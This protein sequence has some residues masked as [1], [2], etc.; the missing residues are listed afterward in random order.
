M[1]KELISIIV[2]VYNVEEYLKRC[3]DSLVNQ[4]YSN[5]EIILVNDGSTDKSLSI[6]KDYEKKSNGKIICLDKKNGGVSDARNFGLEHAKGEYVTFVDSDDYVE[7][8]LIEKLYNETKKCNPALVILNARNF[9]DDGFIKTNQLLSERIEINKKQCIK[10]LFLEKKFFS[11]SWGKLYQTE[12][13]KKIKFDRSMKIAEDFKYLIEYL[14]LCNDDEKFILIPDRLYY[15]YLRQGSAIRSGFDERWIDEIN[16]CKTLINDSL[17]TEYYKYSIRRYIRINITCAIKFNLK[18]ENYDYIR[19]N[20]L[21]YKKDYLTFKKVTIKEKIKYIL[22][23][24]FYPLICLK[25][26]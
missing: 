20:I 5:I 23:A 24:Y 13:A 22:V 4:T 26:R 18:K 15:Y 14:K 17:N 3:I 6:C 7:K 12:K 25:R 2:P 19:K 16:L 9:N 21:Q 1:K 8:N 11:V 10:E